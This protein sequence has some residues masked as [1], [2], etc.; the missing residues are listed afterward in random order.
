MFSSASFF[1]SNQRRCVEMHSF[2]EPHLYYLAVIDFDFL[3]IGFSDY[4]TFGLFGFQTIG[5]ADYWAF[6]LLGLQTI[7]TSNYWTLWQLSFQTI[8]ISNYWTF[9]ILGWYLFFKQWY[10]NKLPEWHFLK[11]Q[12]TPNQRLELWSLKVL[13]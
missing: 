12:I 2:I 13:I 1:H 7:G 10:W 8:G 6:R 3:T 4:W 9:R 5:L 11:L